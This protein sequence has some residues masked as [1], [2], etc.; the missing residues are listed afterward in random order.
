MYCQTDCKYNKKMTIFSLTAIYTVAPRH[1]KFICY[2][3]GFC[4]YLPEINYCKTRGTSQSY[5]DESASGGTEVRRSAVGP[6]LHD[7]QCGLR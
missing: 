2:A 5:I 3:L 6:H 7:T 4:V 1:S